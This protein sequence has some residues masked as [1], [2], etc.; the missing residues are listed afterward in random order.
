L[1]WTPKEESGYV[2]RFAKLVD[3]YI[4]SS[5][6][7]IE[8]LPFTTG[9]VAFAPLNQEYLPKRAPYFFTNAGIDFKMR[10]KSN[11]ILDL[12][13]N[14]DFGQVELDPAVINLTASE[15]YYE[16][17]RPFFIEGAGIFNFG[18]GGT[19]YISCF[20]WK[21]PRFFYSRRIGRLPQGYLDSG[22]NVLFSDW[23]TILGAAKL[24]GKIGKGW[25]IGFI[26]ALTEREF[27]ETELN[28]EGKRVE[29]EPFSFYG[30]LRIQKEFNE[31]RQGLGFIT[32]SVLRDFQS[33]DL[34]SSLGKSALSLA[35]DGWTY[36]NAKRSWVVTGWLGGTKVT[37]TKEAISNL[38][39]SYLHYYQ[40]PD[41]THV[42]LNENATSLNG[43][44]GRVY[45]SK[46]GGTF[47]FNAAL[48]AISPGFD[49][50]DIGFQ[51]LQD[52]INAHIHAGYV[53]LHPGKI[54]RNWHFVL[55]AARS[56]DFGW[57]KTY[58]LRFFRGI[59]Q[60]LNY[61]EGSL[62]LIYCPDRWSNTLTRG[63][64]L[65]KDPAYVQVD[66]DINSDDRKP[67]V[68]SIGSSFQKGKAGDVAES[69][70]FGLQWKLNNNISMEL[71]P[72]YGFNHR[73]AQWVGNF[74]DISMAKTYG[75]RYVFAD[76]KQKILSCAF[77]IN[78]FFSPRV[79]LQAYIQPY[80]TVGK[81]NKFKELAKPKSFDFNV[82]G[83]R[84]STISYGDGTYLVDPDGKG[85]ALPFSFSN[86]DFNY[87]SLRGTIILRWEYQ[88]GSS[89]YAVWT[90]RREDY[91]NPGDF[92]LGRDLRTLFQGP[93]ENIFMVKFTYRFDLN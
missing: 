5:K 27:D 29:V 71:N 85:P 74:Q 18:S 53:H 35:I 69:A 8:L 34:K 7:I 25:N 15:T 66:A 79:S 78:W 19:P 42:N 2:S 4:S 36:L 16:E 63:G 90:Q 37:G 67:L 86:P 80:I 30:L 9:K 11:L 61:W 91:S 72:S 58:D 62:S 81:Y 43:W 49:T 54:F 70:S 56:Y 76:F 64:P 3:I 57:N 6:K 31:A 21:D 46:L 73:I 41:A 84:N 14:P 88:L 60:L 17:K 23:V 87:K 20:G 24:T 28:G 92:S 77:R 89:I 51:F 1:A 68:L 39:Q 13:I 47:L 75:Y 33:D 12:S 52:T 48:G 22:R 10:L 44:A 26:S 50:T 82:F 93:G 45:L 59:A 32:T 40:R 65:T 55:V 83:E 38:Q